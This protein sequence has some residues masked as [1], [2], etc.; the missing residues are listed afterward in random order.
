MNEDIRNIIV[1]YCDQIKLEADTQTISK[2]V[3]SV[4]TI[5]QKMYMDL[6]GLKDIRYN[7]IP[8]SDND[9]KK[10]HCC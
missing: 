10:G 7:C 8:K 4:D 6:Y 1:K 9:D 2:A 3:K 5:V